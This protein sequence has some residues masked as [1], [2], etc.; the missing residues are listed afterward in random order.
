MKFVE[1]P[2]I[3]KNEYINLRFKEKRKTVVKQKLSMKSGEE[4]SLIKSELEFES[5][6]NEM[7]FYNF[8][9]VLIEFINKKHKS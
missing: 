4:R 7:F 2:I 5:A 6:F 1:D 3:D 8:E 9:N